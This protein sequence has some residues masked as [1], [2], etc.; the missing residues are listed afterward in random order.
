MA[1]SV[2]GVQTCALPI[3]CPTCHCFALHDEQAGGQHRRIRT[4]D[5]CAFPGFTQEASGH[6]PRTRQ[7][8]R[9]RQRVLHKFRFAAEAFGDIFCVGCGRCVG[10]C[11]ANVDIRETLTE[12]PQ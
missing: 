11:P 6:N 5:A 9:M 12:V 4:Q 1:R 8:L 10:G 7:G 3:L 2:T